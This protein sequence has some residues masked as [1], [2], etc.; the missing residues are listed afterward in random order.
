VRSEAKL[1]KKDLGDVYE[2]RKSER[3]D[4]CGG[5]HFTA[6]K[7][8]A[9]RRA[10]KSRGL[11]LALP[12][13]R[14]MDQTRWTECDSGSARDRFQLRGKELETDESCIL[15]G[16]GGGLMPPEEAKKARGG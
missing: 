2:P 1:T 13:Q 9:R 7:A 6:G 15:H 10:E 14:G 5:K 12:K 16:R 4:W 3:L 11:E 8:K